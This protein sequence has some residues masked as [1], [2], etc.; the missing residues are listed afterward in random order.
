MPTPAILKILFIEQVLTTSDA[1]YKLVR[2]SIWKQETGQVQVFHP[3]YDHWLKLYIRKKHTLG[4]Y[5]INLSTYSSTLT[6]LWFKAVQPIHLL[7]H[8]IFNTCMTDLYPA[9]AVNSC[10]IYKLEKLSDQW[11]QAKLLPSSPLGNS[12]P[13]SPLLHAFGIPN[14]VTLHAFRIPAQET[15]L[16]WNS[17]M[18]PLVW[19]WIFS[20]NITH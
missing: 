14:Y 11:F 4:L 16:P 6:P 2:H 10:L 17:K 1:V 13:N 9:S 3:Q 12:E 5:L 8:V 20:W 15:P 19:V 7:I 18:L